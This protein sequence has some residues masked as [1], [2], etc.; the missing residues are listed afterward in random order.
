MKLLKDFVRWFFY[1]TTAVLMICAFHFSVSGDDLIPT[2]TL[3]QI[4]L[5]GFLTAGV[6]AL[7]YPREGRKRGRIFSQCLLHYGALCAVMIVSGHCFGWLEYDFGGIA[8]MLA[9]VAVVYLIC[10]GTHYLIDLHDADKINRRLREKYG[11]EMT[12]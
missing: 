9:S 8:M 12:Q 10:F 5:A 1:I 7:L 11:E 2:K 3:W 6:T 4:L